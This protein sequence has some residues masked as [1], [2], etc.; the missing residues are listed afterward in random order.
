[1]LAKLTYKFAHVL[2]ISYE[3][4]KQPTQITITQFA[5]HSFTSAQLTIRNYTVQKQGKLK[6]SE[7]H[8]KNSKKSTLHKRVTNSSFA[9][10]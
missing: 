4:V 10:T 6:S 2:P 5:F 9:N 7:V 8:W 3:I 1:M